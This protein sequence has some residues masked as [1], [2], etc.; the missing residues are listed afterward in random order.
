MTLWIKLVG[1]LTKDCERKIFRR[2][3]FVLGVNK[4]LVNS[5]LRSLQLPRE[6]METIFP[7]QQFF[8]CSGNPTRIKHTEWESIEYFAI[9]SSSIE[10]CGIGFATQKNTGRRNFAGGT[11]VA[12]T[13]NTWGTD[14]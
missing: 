12:R 7:P 14:V 1:Q 10:C 11:K 13:H 2:D 5:S 9:Q 4:V 3:F 6:D 8:F